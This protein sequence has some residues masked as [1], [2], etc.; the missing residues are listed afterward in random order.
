MG[1]AVLCFRHS[2]FGFRHS[3]PT[4]STPKVPFIPVVPN[5]PSTSTLPATDE[6]LGITA[7]LDSF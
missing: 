2:S 1:V 5:I 3:H 7:D 4:A 6:Y